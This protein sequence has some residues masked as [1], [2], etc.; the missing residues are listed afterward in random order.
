MDILISSNLERQLF[1]LSG[2]DGDLIASLMQ[3]LNSNRRFEIPQNLMAKVQEVFAAYSTSN[4]ECLATIKD[5]LDA[6]SYLLDPHTAVAYAAA[7]KHAQGRPVLIAA[8]AHWAKFGINVYRALH[9][10]AAEE[11]LP[12][13]IADMSGCQLNR[14]IAAETNQAHIPANL[15]ELDRIPVRF[16]QIIDS[17][18]PSIENAVSKFVENVAP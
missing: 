8:T 6:H 18:V 15:D 10:I 1:E 9:G 16:E 2:R 13:E 7:R 11:P 14:L 4:E 12:Q 3:D 17:D 5:V